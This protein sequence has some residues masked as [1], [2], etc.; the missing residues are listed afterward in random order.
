MNRFYVISNLSRK[1][2]API[3]LGNNLF[4]AG[5][6]SLHTPAVYLQLAVTYSGD[7]N[8]GEK[9]SVKQK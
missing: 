9:G 7:L 3:W 4:I 1:K 8:A 2:V 6:P 5:Y